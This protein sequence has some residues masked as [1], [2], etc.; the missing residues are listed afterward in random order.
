MESEEALA[1]HNSQKRLLDPR[2]RLALNSLCRPGWL[3]ICS[4]LLSRPPG[5][6]G[7]QLCVTTLSWTGV[8]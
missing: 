8:I 5:L 2:T 4:S 6:L 3:Q 7:L 1:V